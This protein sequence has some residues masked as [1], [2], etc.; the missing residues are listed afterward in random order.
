MSK[1]WLIG[2]T[3]FDH[4]GIHEKFR[5]EFSSLEDHNETIHQNIL[6]GKSKR[7]NLWLLGDIIIGPEALWRIKEYSDRFNQVV[8][9]LGNHDHK[10]LIPYCKD[11]PNVQF[12]GI[13]KRWGFWLSHAPIH[14]QEL[15]RANSVHGHTHSKNVDNPHY[16]SVSCE[17][18]NYKPVTIQNIKEIF[19]SRGIVPTERQLQGS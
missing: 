9:C 17:N 6:Q 16:F 3:H 5:T 12:Y 13:T 4:K 2:D 10:T 18:V 15:Y 14:P 19:A 7:D 11:L 8:I 1:V